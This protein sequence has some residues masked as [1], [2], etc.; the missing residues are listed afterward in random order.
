MIILSK[1]Y[2]GKNIILLSLMISIIIGINFPVL[3]YS[4][5]VF[6][7]GDK[8]PGCSCL[9]MYT[10][11]DCLDEKDGPAKF[12]CTSNYNAGST[13]KLTV[14]VCFP[15]KGESGEAFAFMA[16]TG[17]C[18]WSVFEKCCL[19]GDM[20]E[21]YP[22]CG[23]CDDNEE[24]AF[25]SNLV[26]CI[27]I[28]G[29]QEEL[30]AFFPNG[31]RFYRDLVD[32]EYQTDTCIKEVDCE[33]LF[34]GNSI[35]ISCAASN[36]T[37]QSSGAKFGINITFCEH[38]SWGIG[39]EKINSFIPLAGANGSIVVKVNRRS[40]FDPFSLLF[41]VTE[42]PAGSSVAWV[43]RIDRNYKGPDDGRHPNEVGL[44]DEWKWTF[45]YCNEWRKEWDEDCPCDNWE[46]YC[47]YCDDCCDID[48][49]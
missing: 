26:M 9:S 25:G 22:Y 11:L 32:G 43:D 18:N 28:T 29:S 2:K 21:E 3:V 33:Y 7:N 36:N 17:S 45:E 10:H 34:A 37:T 13:I 1:L 24:C 20:E 39:E 48:R 49:L 38:A 23:V 8:C 12:I 44:Q 16:N 31:V 46:S 42:C 5:V 41:D 30:E 35:G 6:T 4:E 14:D 40:N 27:K 15:E 47:C 19:C